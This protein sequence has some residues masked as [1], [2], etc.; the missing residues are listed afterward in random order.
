MQIL[1]KLKKYNFYLM[2]KVNMYKRFNSRE[3][4]LKNIKSFN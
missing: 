3:D 4:V 1:K 2:Q